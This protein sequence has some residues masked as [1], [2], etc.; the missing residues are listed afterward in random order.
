MYTERSQYMTVVPRVMVSHVV[1]QIRT[2]GWNEIGANIN[3][4]QIAVNGVYVLHC[5]K[6]TQQPM[7]HV[8][9]TQ[10]SQP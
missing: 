4:V 2:R 10:S 5:D 7:K 6:T 9:S 8:H 3:I 1:C